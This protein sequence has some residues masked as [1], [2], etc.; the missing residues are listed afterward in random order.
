MLLVRLPNWLGDAV[1]ATPVVRALSRRTTVWL[2]GRGF[3]EPLFA[4]FPGVRGFSALSEGS[5]GLLRTARSL[6]GRG[7]REALLLPNSLSSALLVFLAGI[8]E[9]MGFST[10][11]RRLLLT[12]AVNPPAESLHQRDYYVYLLEALGFS[13][14]ER[15]LTL[16]VPEAARRRAGE[17]LS[18]L[19]GPLAVLAPGAAYG[20]AKR[21]PPD[22][23]RKLAEELVRRGW[24]VALVGGVNERDAAEGISAGLSRVHNLCGRTDVATAAAVIERATVFVSNDSGL[25]HVA[26]AL[27]RPQVAIFGSTDPRATG[28]LNPRARVVWKGLPCSPCLRRTC[29][30]GYPCLTTVSVEEVLQAVEEIVYS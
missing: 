12:R 19:P 18:G 22:R 11:G 17:L 23:F 16:S 13:V 1:M 3:L 30:R 21:W 14:P 26:A 25:M 6:R 4:C 8:P 20:P 7:F 29:S 9:R 2:L 27:G 24:S 10:D 5:L 28:P 15:S